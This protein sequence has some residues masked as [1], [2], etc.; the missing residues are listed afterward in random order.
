MEEVFK[1]AIRSAPEAAA[2]LITVIVF[3]RNMAKR[4]ELLKEMRDYNHQRADQGFARD[5]ELY[6]TLRETLDV[7]SKTLARVEKML[8]KFADGK[9][10]A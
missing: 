2:I 4:D 8:E 7:N 10:V 3:L 9:A 5:L 6:K 1:E